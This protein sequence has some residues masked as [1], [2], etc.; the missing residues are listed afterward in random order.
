MCA[1]IRL[2]AVK[3]KIL[4]CVCVF[5]QAVVLVALRKQNKLVA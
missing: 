4:L 3:K 5:S 2:V 1:M